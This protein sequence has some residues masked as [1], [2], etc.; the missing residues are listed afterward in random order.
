MS[1]MIGGSVLAA[2]LATAGA[3]SGVAA[4]G[5][6]MAKGAKAKRQGRIKEDEAKKEE[7]RLELF[8]LNRQAVIDQSSDIR[9]MKAEVFNPYQ[10]LGVAMKAA[11]MQIEQT[12]EDLASVLDNI[13]QSGGSA[14]GATQLAKM[15]AASKAQVSA[16]IENQEAANQ[17]ARIEGEGK[18]QAMKMQIEKLALAEEQNVWAKQET[19]DLTQMDRLQNKSDNLA[20][21]ANQLSQQGDAMVMAGLS[22]ISS[23]LMGAGSSV[24]GGGD[25]GGDGL[26]G[27]GESPAGTTTDG[28]SSFAPEG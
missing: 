3:A 15:A 28:F 10:N 22:G 9:A 27:L 8:E 14:G 25:G 2:V 1:F 24:V 18:A 6:S 19:R 12:D 11:D 16:S 21:Q 17:K 4:G 20:M 26:Y 13:N 5:A 23:S 7:K